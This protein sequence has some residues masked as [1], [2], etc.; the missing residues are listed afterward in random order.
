MLHFK[1]TTALG[2]PYDLS[3]EE[4]RD[5]QLKRAYLDAIKLDS[6]YSDLK[7]KFKELL[8]VETGKELDSKR[9][10]VEFSSALQLTIAFQCSLRMFFNYFK[11]GMSQGDKEKYL[12]EAQTI[13]DKARISGT[14]VKCRC[15]T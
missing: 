12:E 2:T 14:P 13:T 10:D 3:I 1:F 6:Q 9:K 5:L 15:V 8:E 11:F 4:N 7:D